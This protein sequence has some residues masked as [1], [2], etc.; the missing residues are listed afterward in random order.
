M[1]M[2]GERQRGIQGTTVQRYEALEE[3]DVYRS[4]H[5]RLMI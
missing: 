2:M 3:V 4:R 1:V 5:T